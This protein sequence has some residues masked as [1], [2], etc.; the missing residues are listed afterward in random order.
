MAGRP[1]IFD[2]EDELQLKIDNFFEVCTE[3]EERPTV[4]GLALHL[5]FEG[6]QSLYDYRDNK[7]R[8]E[9]SYPIKKALTRIEYELEKRLENNSVAGVIFALKNMGWKDKTETALTGADG[10]PIQVTGMEIK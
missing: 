9:F 4:T 1:P 8:P 7:N 6:K 10:G 3:T 2:N 5:G